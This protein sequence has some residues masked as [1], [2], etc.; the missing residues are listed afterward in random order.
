M[1][2]VVDTVEIKKLMIDRNISSIAELSS[3]SGINRNTLGAVINGEAYP[4]SKIIGKLIEV[5]LIP[6]DRVGSIFFALKLT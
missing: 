4:S 2:Y 3:I 5:L 1:Q 6:L